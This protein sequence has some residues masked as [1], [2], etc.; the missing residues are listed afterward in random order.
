MS[1]S[2]EE[3]TYVSKQ[4]SSCTPP[5]FEI[6]HSAADMTVSQ[7]VCSSK[8]GQTG[9]RKVTS[10]G[11]SSP[12]PIPGLGSGV[13][14]MRVKEGTKIRNLLHFAISRLQGEGHVAPISQVMFTGLG[15]AI[16]KTI[17]CAEIVKRKVQ[18]LHQVSKLQ[19]RNIQEVWENQEGER[20]N[21]RKTVPSICILLSKEPLDPQEL[22]YQ[23]PTETSSRSEEEEQAG[24][25]ASTGKRSF[26]HSSHGILPNAK[27]TAMGHSRQAAPS[28]Q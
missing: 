7:S 6:Y 23:S 1:L 26:R 19:Y 13:L 17:T 22:G 21:V 16:T 25:T 12:C 3:L 15:R 5:V 28:Y 27:R 24:A 2:S 14:E 11:E 20:V 9:F 8:P 4:S 18:G 10:I